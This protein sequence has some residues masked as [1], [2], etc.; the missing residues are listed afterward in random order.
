[1]RVPVESEIS[2]AS[3][4]KSVGLS[5]FLWLRSRSWVR[6]APIPTALLP[7]WHGS[8]H[9]ALRTL[10]EL[11]W[12]IGTESSRASALQEKLDEF[13][14]YILTNVAAIPNYADRHR[15]GGPIATGFVESAVNQIAWRSVRAE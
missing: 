3:L 14:N 5:K 8:P 10:D 7:L 13:M 15:H 11:T 1:L 12:D 9:R 6:P 2:T 4:S